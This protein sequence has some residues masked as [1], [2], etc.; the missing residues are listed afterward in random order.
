MVKRSADATANTPTTVPIGRIHA[1]T[2]M[3]LATSRSP[4]YKGMWYNS[5][6]KSV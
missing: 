5:E 2:P 4:S 1:L 3:V 6:P